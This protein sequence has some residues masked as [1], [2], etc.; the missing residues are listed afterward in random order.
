MERR[1]I[2]RVDCSRRLLETRLLLRR[3]DGA[4][5]G[6][7]DRDDDDSYGGGGALPDP[8]QMHWRVSRLRR[9]LDELR[10][11]GN[12]LAVRVASMTMEN[13]E[14]E[15]GLSTNSEKVRIARERLDR[16]RRCLLDES[17]GGGGGERTDDGAVGTWRNG[18]GLRDALLSG[19]Q[20]IQTLRFHLACRVFDM[21]RLDVGGKYSDR[22]DGGGGGGQEPDDPAG[23]KIGNECATG[24]GK[25]GGLPLPHAGPVLYG[26][27]PSAVLASSLRLVASVTQL[28]A[29]CLGVILPHPILICFEECHK[30]GSIYDFDGDVIDLSSNI[31]GRDDDGDDVDDEYFGG[32]DNRTQLCGACLNEGMSRTSPTKSPTQQH[33]R[34]SPYSPEK[35]RSSFL[36]IVGSSARKVVSLTTSAT[37][38][39]FTNMPALPSGNNQ[40]HDPSPNASL[41]GNNDPSPA[42]AISYYAVSMSPDSISRRVDRASFAYLRENHDASATEYVLNP[43]RWGDD[44]SAR[45]GG[46]E[47]NTG[48]GGDD[49]DGRTRRPPT[50]T[51]FS[52]REEFRAAEERFATGLQLLQNDIVALC[53]RAGV[54]VSTLWPAESVLLNLHSLCRHCRRMADGGNIH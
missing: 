48:R 1:E 9:H 47:S 19:T 46:S 40:D 51:T 30:C 42:F 54:D 3:R 37:S 17:G 20:E 32:D 25:I 6:M 23:A 12:D 5:S 53:F 16:M 35:R 14:R 44:A 11:R 21:H 36:A 34:S 18:G 50:R 8:N 31:D 38:R 41:S 7:D 43:P 15:E 13:D 39:A 27:I 45:G 4:D 29:S 28:V 52:D 26:V 22:S 10:G 24:V 2:A 33:P 49:A